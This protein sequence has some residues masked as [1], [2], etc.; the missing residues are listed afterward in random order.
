[1]S[2]NKYKPL[3]GRV[4]IKREVMEKTKGGILIPDTQKKRHAKC[5]GI[6]ISVGPS[7]E[8]V[9]EGDHVVFGKHSGTWLDSTYTGTAENEDGTTF[10]C[11]D[12]DILAIIEGE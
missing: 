2:E 1:M 3:F 8:G 10:I 9:K 12:E 5:E 4:I 11:Q 6:V 7:A